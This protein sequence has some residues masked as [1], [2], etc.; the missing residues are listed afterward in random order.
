MKSIIPTPESLQTLVTQSSRLTQFIIATLVCVLIGIVWFK[1]QH[2]LIGPIIAILP[3]AG[4]IVLKQPFPFALGFIIFSFFR[5]HEVFPQLYPFR[6]PQ[7]LALGTLVSLSW[8]LWTQRL[9]VYWTRELSIFAIFFILVSIGVIFASNRGEAMASYTG[10]YIK[11]FVMI[12]AISWLAASLNSLRQISHTILFSGILVGAITLMNKAKGIGLVEGTRVTIGRDIGSML[13]DPNDLA[14]VLLFPAGFALSYILNRGVSWP[15]RLFALFAFCIILGAVIATQSRGGLLGIASIMGVFAYRRIKSKA[16]FGFA[17]VIAVIVLF[18]LAGI[19][20]RA[21]GGAHEAG[22]DES[23][24]GRIY[25]WQAA[26]K[27]ASQ[28]PLTGVGP[29]NFTL[30]YWVYSDFWDGKNHAVH[31]TWFGVLAETGFLG[32]IIFITMI[33]IIFKRVLICLA[34]LS[35][36]GTFSNNPKRAEAFTLAEGILASLVGFIVSATFLTMGFTWPVYILLALSTALGRYISNL[37]YEML[38]GVSQD[39][40]F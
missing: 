29:N 3:L 16:L 30:N 9:Q 37:Q 8:S 2:P 34:T 17:A 32:L 28:N 31:S 11:I 21:S 15:M 12:V 19:N 14:L 40:K 4:L 39:A 1:V 22:I 38:Q 13:G 36:K 26:I 5:L 10:N 20:D 27:M 35:P 7:L 33:V 6:I 25:A 18:T 23:A 24:M